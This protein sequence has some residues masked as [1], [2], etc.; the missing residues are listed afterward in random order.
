MATTE[1][2]QAR[3]VE[4]RKAL[5]Q[6]AGLISS[7]RSI[8]ELLHGEPIAKIAEAFDAVRVTIYALDPKNNQLYSISKTGAAP[9]CLK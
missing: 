4:Q 1:A 2:A 9:F 8:E 6:L 5:Q 7:V 3:E